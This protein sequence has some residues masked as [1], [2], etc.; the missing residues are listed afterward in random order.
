MGVLDKSFVKVKQD[1][2]KFALKKKKE[3]KIFENSCCVMS[4]IIMFY[5]K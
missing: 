1:F 3:I 5:G 4:Q 2:G